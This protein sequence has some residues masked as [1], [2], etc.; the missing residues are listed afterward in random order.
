[1]HDV[2]ILAGRAAVIA[3]LAWVGATV[4]IAVPLLVT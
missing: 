1:M 2:L 3:L 4:A